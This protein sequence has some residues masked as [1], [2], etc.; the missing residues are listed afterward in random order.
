MSQWIALATNKLE[1]FCSDLPGDTSLDKRT[2]VFLNVNNHTI[3]IEV[4]G[5]LR[6]V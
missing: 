3:V 1:L 6:K 2:T 5:Y 4:S